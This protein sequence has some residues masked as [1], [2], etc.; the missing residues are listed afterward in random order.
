MSTTSSATNL[1]NEA[2]QVAYDV[3]TGILQG[4]DSF[5]S[6]IGDLIGAYIV[7]KLIFSMPVIGT[8]LKGLLGGVGLRV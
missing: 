3:A 4:V 5:S 7:I 1:A 6:V 8:F 2:L